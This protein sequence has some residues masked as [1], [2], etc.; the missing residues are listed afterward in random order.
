MTPQNTIKS[1]QSK[2]NPADFEQKVLEGK[3][4]QEEIGIC[5]SATEAGRKRPFESLAD[6]RDEQGQEG[7]SGH[8]IDGGQ[9]RAQPSPNKHSKDEAPRT[10]DANAFDWMGEGR[11][12]L[13]EQPRTDI[14]K[15]GPLMHGYQ[16]GLLSCC[17]NND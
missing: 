1:E 15:A 5:N 8:N 14:A 11:F 6:E 13:T 3:M 4:K 17:D 10:E 7:E 16:V 12:H 9:R 2:A